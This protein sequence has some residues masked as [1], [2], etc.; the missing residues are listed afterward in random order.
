MFYVK[1]SSVPFTSL[2]SR[3]TTMNWNIIQNQRHFQ[4]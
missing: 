2:Y 4:P 3:I 1:F